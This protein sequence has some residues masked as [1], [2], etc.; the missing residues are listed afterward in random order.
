MVVIDVEHGNARAATVA[1]LLRRKRRI[2]EE[3]I[4]TVGRITGMMAGRA[5]S[6]KA[7][8][9][10]SATSAAAVSADC[11]E[12]SAASQVPSTI[13]VPASNA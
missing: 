8:R 5:A 6:A 4:A 11:A 1:Q 10:P 13:G 3:A 2:V 12:A 9:S 7:L